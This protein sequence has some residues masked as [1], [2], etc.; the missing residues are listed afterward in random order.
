MR[1]RPGGAELLAEARRLLREE[2]LPSLEGRRR[3]EGLMIANA[4]GMAE[5]E[6]RAGERPLLAEK[7]ALG[8]LLG[9]D[10]D[11]ATLNAA[12]AAALRDGRLAADPKAY[13]ALLEEVR[14]RLAESNPKALET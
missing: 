2:L 7:A 1:D 3:F 4:L 9:R 11:L 14:N 8:D 13:R 5:R 10:G 12:F 6:L